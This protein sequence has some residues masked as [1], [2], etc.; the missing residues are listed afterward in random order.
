LLDN[1][2]FLR[3]YFVFIKSLLLHSR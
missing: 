3:T 2:L 1:H